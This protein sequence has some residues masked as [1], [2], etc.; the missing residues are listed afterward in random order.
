[1]V[2][3]HGGRFNK[4]GWQQQAEMLSNAGFRVVAF[5]F[6]S[7][8]ER[9]HLDVLG[10]IAYLRNSGAKSIAVIGASMG[11]DYAAEAC[12]AQ[13]N[14]I[15]R[16]VLLA[17]GEYTTLK[18]CKARKLYIMTRDD[19]IGDNQARMPPIR[20]KYDEASEPKQFVALEGSAH[21]QAIFASDQ[22]ERLTQ[23][24]LR[25]LTAP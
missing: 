22:G 7:Q 2:L 8:E 16:L 15:D 14:Q 6:R 19:I 5:D 20:K 18:R 23:E 3:A 24:I 9:R 21:A 13:P 12:E 17:A 11:G 10:A 1:V 25:F 4:E